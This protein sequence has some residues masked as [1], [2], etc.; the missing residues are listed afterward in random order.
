[1]NGWIKLHRSVLSSEVFKNPYLFKVWVWCLTKASTKPR[2]LTVGLQTIH[3]QE[4]QFVY[5]LLQASE[6]LD[7][8]KSSLDRYLKKLEKMGNV[9]IKHTNKY[10]ILTVK[11]WGFY[12][13]PGNGKADDVGNKW[14]TNG[15]KQEGKEYISKR[16]FGSF[17][18]VMLSDDNYEAL[19]NQFPDDYRERIEHLSSYMKSTGKEYADHYATIVSWANKKRSGKKERR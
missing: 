7:I 19:K 11:N 5:G 13:G 8:P 6:E 15:N 9:G 1:M 16:P 18:N 12:Q 17:R 14:E 10:S 3:L 4:G 2:K